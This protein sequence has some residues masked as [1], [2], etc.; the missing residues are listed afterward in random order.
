[1]LNRFSFMVVGVA[2][3]VSFEKVFMVTH[4]W[5]DDYGHIWGVRF[6]QF[7]PEKQP[8]FTLTLSGYALS[9]FAR[10]VS[11]SVIGD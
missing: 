2:G 10:I 8:S 1:M 11:L 6:R 4:T 9:I 3:V 7:E 5:P